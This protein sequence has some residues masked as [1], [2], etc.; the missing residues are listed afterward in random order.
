MTR[1]STFLLSADLSAG[2]AGFAFSV[3]SPSGFCAL[4]P[5]C[6]SAAAPQKAARTSASGFFASGLAAAGSADFGASPVGSPRGFCAFRPDCAGAAAQSAARSARPAA[7]LAAARSREGFVC[8]RRILPPRP[9][10][11]GAGR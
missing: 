8:A 1:A 5:D 6:A 4:R 10:D 7:A 9:L 2:S 3:G 11:A